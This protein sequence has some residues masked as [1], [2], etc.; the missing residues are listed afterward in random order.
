MRKQHIS[1]IR[2]LRWAIVA[3]FLV[4]SLELLRQTVFSAASVWPARAAAILVCASIVCVLNFPAIYKSTVQ[5]DKCPAYLIENLPEIACIIG[6][7]GR[8]K[9][10]N[11]NLEAVLGYTAEEIEKLTV[12]DAIA[13]ESTALVG[14]TAGQ[15]RPLSTFSTSAEEFVVPAGFARVWHPEVDFETQDLG[16]RQPC[17]VWPARPFEWLMDSG[18]TPWRENH[19]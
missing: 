3:V 9:Q 13:E 5:S 7:H 6:D 1:F 16:F 11:S 17:K 19:Q 18:S 8:F 10:W 14:V 4:A 15:P 12:F 2:V